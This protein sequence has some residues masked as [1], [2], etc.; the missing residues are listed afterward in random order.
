MSR[1]VT[2]IAVMLLSLLA[3]ACGRSIDTPAAAPGPDQSRPASTPETQRC[4]N[5][6]DGYSL[7]YPV[8]WHTSTGDVLPT[9]TVFDDEPV[10]L[11]EGTEV[12]F[13]VTVFLD[14]VDRP[15]SDLDDDDLAIDVV[16]R[17]TGRIDD[18]DAVEVRFRSTG[19]GLLPEDVI[20]HRIL[21]DLREGAT[22]MAS[23]YELDGRPLEDNVDTM[24]RMLRTLETTPAAGAS[25][26]TASAPPFQGPTRT[27]T[28]DGSG[29]AV[30]VTGIEVAAHDGYDRI[31][32]EIDG[33][34][35]PGWH[36][37]YVDRPAHQGSG[38]EAEV[39]GDATLHLFITNT[40]YPSDTGID[41]YSGPDR[42][43]GP[44][45]VREVLYGNIYEGDTELFIG[46]D[47]RRPFRVFLL[48]EPSRV[49]LDVRHD[50]G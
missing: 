32:F 41:E 14:V 6:Q 4:V 42:V 45:T 28:S 47:R 26:A 2:T 20:G 33:D 16:E 27:D 17:Q 48:D 15:I 12:P 29:A 21:L 30:N 38:R 36:A 1:Y 50:T 43:E 11:T 44:G 9:C 19:H 40:G 34:G 7:S 13:D 49:V 18:R 22:L 3:G 5:P 10:E 37:E 8:G 39:A 25:P 23:T 35:T 46:V 31:V 24:R